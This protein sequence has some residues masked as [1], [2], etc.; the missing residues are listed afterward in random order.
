MKINYLTGALHQLH[1]CIAPETD[2][3]N[4][5]CSTVGARVHIYTV[6]CTTAPLI[7]DCISIYY[8]KLN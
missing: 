2:M 7:N 3:Y 1:Q 4:T 8:E 6:H 5:P